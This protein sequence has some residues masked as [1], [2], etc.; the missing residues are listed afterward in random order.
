[1]KLNKQQETASWKKLLGLMPF[2]K[3]NM[4]WLVLNMV[5]STS[6]ALFTFGNALV[7]QQLTDAV[8]QTDTGAF[9][10]WLYIA[11]AIVAAGMVI[12]YGLRY[13]SGRYVTQTL[14]DLRAR[15]SEHIQHLPMSSVE[16]H[17]TGDLVSR[18]NNDIGQIPGLLT[19]IADIVYQPVLFVGSFVY[20]LLI[21]WKLLLFSCILIPISAALYN[22][23][24]KPMEELSRKNLEGHSRANSII[25]DTIAGIPI[26]KAFNLQK[27]MLGKYSN[28]VRGIETQ[29]LA[30]DRREALLLTLFLALRYIP[31]LVCPLYG[32]YLALRGEITPG[33]V[34]AANV[35]IWNIFQPV[36]A[37]LEL[38]RQV[39]TTTPAVERVLEILD[40][41]PEHKGAPEVVRDQKHSPLEF[42]A[43]SFS[44]DGEANTLDQLSFTV[45]NGKVVALVGASGSGKSTILK[46]I[47][48]FCEPAVG[49][50][51][52]FGQDLAT[53]DLASARQHM[54]LVSQETYLFPTTITENIGYGRPGST[55]GD[56]IAAAQLANAHDFIMEL[57]DGYSTDIGERGV[58]LSGGQRQRIALA[59]AILKDAPILLLDEPTSAL[60]TQSE[61]LVQAALERF[62]QDR[63]VLVVAHR[64]STIHNADEILLIDQGCVQERG[65]HKTLMETDSLYRNLYLKQIVS[66]DSTVKQNTTLEASH[67]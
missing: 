63:T 12:H 52:L 62:M 45:A 7:L 67:D 36:E 57:P 21:S 34:V 40:E 64:L 47:C 46:L 1:M 29:S 24:S 20:L 27:V 51:R 33:S 23:V 6:R 2:V 10:D 13:A 37:F 14:Q 65:T 42:E 59:R 39:R 26:V 22:K 44:Y 41:V 9:R 4:L 48:G 15:I 28:V 30:M 3:P 53:S 56:I 18:L 60:D 8:V 54:S 16:A 49:H 50:I 66:V 32:G 5:F 38:L 43:L 17:H 31:Q 58:R 11:G 19:S 25:Q 55:Q 35:L 61:A